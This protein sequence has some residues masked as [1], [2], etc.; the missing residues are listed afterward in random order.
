MSFVIS[1]SQPLADELGRIARQEIDKSVAILK[2]GRRRRDRGVHETRKRVKKLRG[3]FGLL[4][5]LDPP[6]LRTEN[7]RYGELSRALSSGR[8][9]TAMVENFERLERDYPNSFADGA[10]NSLKALLVA[11]R[12]RILR[13]EAQLG[14]A[15]EAAIEA[16]VE[17]RT[18]LAPLSG[19]PN[20]ALAADVIAAGLTRTWEKARRSARRAARRGEAEA[21]H[22]LRKATKA[23][24]MHMSLLEPYWPRPFKPRRDAVKRLGDRLGEVNDIDMMRVW[25]AGEPEIDSAGGQRLLEV[26]ARK[27]KRLR[28]ECLGM[29]SLLFRQRPDH[30]AA[31][32]AKAYVAAARA[33][34]RSGRDR[35]A[36]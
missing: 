4:R 19:P 7:L 23:H 13:E 6:L 12:D 33:P 9:A 29:A 3:L 11:R 14:A 17:G 1:H 8:D 18:A 22:D 24:F 25:L 10:A 32:V 5:A 16:F 34:I 27:E 2:A 30:T 28:K 36:A 26:M 31:R 20:S 35:I 21:F 15:I